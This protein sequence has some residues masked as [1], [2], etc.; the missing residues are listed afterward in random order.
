M[1]E[2]GLFSRQRQNFPEFVEIYQMELTPLFIGA[3]AGLVIA[4]VLFTLLHKSNSVSKQ[5]YEGL[6][7]RLND[8]SNA[9]K[10]TEEKLRSQQELASSFQ[11]KAESK[12]AELTS[13]LSRT[14]TLEATLKM[15]GER[16]KEITAALTEQTET[17]KS[18]QTEIN[19]AKQKLAE[20][21]ANNA[22]LLDKL[23]T[24]KQDIT[25]LQKT[26]HLQFEK[27]AQQIFEEKSGK[28]T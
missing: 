4:Y 14:A 6:A 9:L 1:N 20:Y 25:E 8:T 24:Q 13:L 23:S 27:L 2:Q 11:Q 19:S 17:N 3:I 28:F 16:L 18:Q 5:D 12:D 15:N 22:A 7:A 21:T 10:F 26:A